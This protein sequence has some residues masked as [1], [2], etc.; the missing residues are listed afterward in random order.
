MRKQA[1]RISDREALVSDKQITINDCQS[2]FFVKFVKLNSQNIKTLTIAQL[3]VKLLGREAKL[4][5]I[6]GQKRSKNK[7][8]TQKL[9]FL[10]GNK[11]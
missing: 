5:K 3:E 8:K 9:V 7:K 10:R 1:E 11:A 2:Y 6:R 4:G